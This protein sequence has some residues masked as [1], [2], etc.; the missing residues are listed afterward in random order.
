[1]AETIYVMKRTIDQRCIALS[2]SPGSVQFVS[3][4]STAIKNILWMYCHKPATGSSTAQMHIKMSVKD[5][6]SINCLMLWT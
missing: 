6:V 1:M 2:I 4:G 5:S 3:S